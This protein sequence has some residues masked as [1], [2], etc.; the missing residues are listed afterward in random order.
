MDFLEISFFSRAIGPFVVRSGTGELT[1]QGYRSTL[2]KEAPTV[3]NPVMGEALQ[4][5]ITPYQSIKSSS[6]GHRSTR[7]TFKTCNRYR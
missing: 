6:T 2:S 5:I 3:G 7:P 4:R 1:Y